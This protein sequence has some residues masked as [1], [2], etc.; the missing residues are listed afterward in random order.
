VQLEGGA[1]TTMDRLAVGDR[2]R[3]ASGA[4]SDVFLFTHAEATGDHT[5]VRLSTAA[6]D[7]TATRGHYVLVNGGVRTAAAAVVVGDVL[8]HLPAGSCGG[9][10]DAVVT[11][12]A[13]VT[14]GGLFNPQTLDGTIVVDGFA[15]STFT[16][17]VEPTLAA[18]ALAPLRAAYTWL[19]LSAGGLPR[20]GPAALV[21]A[22]PKGASV[23]A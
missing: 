3:T 7:L 4:Y 16:T 17:A 14:R 1:V 22:L 9:A 11:A 5:Y 12:V 8:A 10:T 18:A 21:A 13:T 15:A 23:A 6:G 20:G 2:V 19:G